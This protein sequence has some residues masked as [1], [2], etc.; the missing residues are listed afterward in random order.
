MTTAL[1]TP[2]ALHIAVCRGWVPIIGVSMPLLSYDPVLTVVSGAE[3]GLLASVALAPP[4]GL[5]QHA[6]A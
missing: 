2:A 5:D 6:P 3:L 1:L 4:D